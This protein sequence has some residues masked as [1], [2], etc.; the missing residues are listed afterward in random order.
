MSS[1]RWLYLVDAVSI[2]AAAA[3]LG[4]I[5]T[6]V[7]NSGIEMNIAYEMIAMVPPMI[8]AMLINTYVIMHYVRNR[9]DELL[10]GLN[11]V[12]KGDLEVTLDEQNSDEYEPIYRMFNRM[13]KEVR[14]SKE[15][16]DS[17]IN[18]YSH[19]FKTPITSIKGFAQY[20]KKNGDKISGE[21]RGKYLQIIVDES[22]RLTELSSNMLFLSKL[23]ATQ[24][25]TDK[26]E[27]RLD[28]QIRHCLIVMLPHMEKKNIDYDIDCDELSYYG[29]MTF[30]DNVW[31]NLISNAIKYTPEGGKIVVGLKKTD[32]DD[33]YSCMAYVE[34]S[35]IGMDK[36]TF[37]H[38]FDKYYQARSDHGG[39]GIGLSIVKR[40]VTLH[41]GRIEVESAPGK[42]STFKI[43]L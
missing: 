3:A 35:G 12:A 5:V 26:E 31:I 23:E 9:M 33:E 42:G 41:G 22:S 29:N 25:L 20:L 34:D 36:D 4:I 28:E 27:F 30:L 18:D 11:A 43:F 6:M 13:V 2:M 14:M 7:R 19:E 24:I 16:M 17:F 21:E 8:I 38:I 40:I 39:N 32:E 10:E 15:N 37:N 1:F